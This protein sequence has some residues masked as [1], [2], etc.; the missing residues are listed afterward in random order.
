MME[1]T[2]SS[3]ASS[4]ADLQAEVSR[5]RSTLNATVLAMLLFT[6]AINASL[7]YQDHV[8]RKELGPARNLVLDYETVKQPLLN[9][10][11]AGLQTYAQSHP[12]IKPILDRYPIQPKAAD[13][14]P[15]SPPSP[16][17]VPK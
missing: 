11:I 17:M 10:F 5:L 7:Y 6:G 8:A 4:T 16:A 1:P 14:S 13:S 15:I 9:K 3:E 12:D 2:H